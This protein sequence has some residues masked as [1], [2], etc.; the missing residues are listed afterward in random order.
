MRDGKPLAIDLYCGLGGWTE[1][2]LA[3]DYQVI[4]YDIV[5]HAYG[6]HAY[7]A[8]LRLQ[9]V[10]T[11][12]G[13]QFADADLIV[14]SSPCQEFSYRAMPWKRAKA[15]PPPKLG[16]A[17]FETQFR[18]QREAC[19]A[20]GRHIPMVVENVR[21]AIPWVGRSRWNY[22]SYHLWGDVPAL[23]PMTK[24]RAGTK[25]PGL[26]WSKFGQPDYKSSDPAG[27]FRDSAIK[28]EGG[29]W[30]GVAHN[31][32]SGVGRNPDGRD[33]M[34]QKGFQATAAEQRIRNDPRDAKHFRSEEEGIKARSPGH[35]TKPGSGADWFDGGPAK[36]NSRSNKRK[37][38]SALIAKIPFV[39]AQHIART[40]K[41]NEVV[42]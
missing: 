21:G 3:E 37:A 5:A 30:F 35:Y 27:C 12:D 15:L 16:I 4:G 28:N 10:L 33:P 6:D 1:G 17:L 13:A 32:T 31:N 9:D 34:W 2:L 22:G 18:I 7:P 36:H 41:P 38:A 11:L 39:L 24:R 40:Y 14:G 23:M 20:A 29:S 42:A 19:A 25:V 26:D 8:E